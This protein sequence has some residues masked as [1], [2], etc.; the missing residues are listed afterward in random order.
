[1]ISKL[2]L[3]MM[4]G[5]VLGD[6]YFQTEKIA[7][8]KEK[9]FKGVLI[10]SLEYYIALL[11][12]EIPFISIDLFLCAT[13]MAIAH[14]FID[15]IKYIIIKKK[16][17]RKTGIIFVVDQFFHILSIFILAYYMNCINFHVTNF[18]I[19]ENVFTTFDIDKVIIA[20]WILALLV[21]HIPAN[22]L[23]QNLLSGYKPREQGEKLIEIDNKI[24]RKIGTIER[25][26]MLMFIAMDQYAAMGLVL[27]AKSIARY[28]KIAKDEKFAEYYLLGTLLS[29]M[30]VVFCKMVILK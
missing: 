17:I 21:L 11:C 15:A 22:I 4:I 29:T 8:Q 23:I 2:L 13:Y 18:K 7:K 1:M 16:K 12:V 9:M 6:F 25:Y 19:V 20:K 28:D 3:L 27:T 26:I 10:H 24:G 14:L 5:H 30:C